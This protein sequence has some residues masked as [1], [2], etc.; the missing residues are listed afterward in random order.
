MAR[1]LRIQYPGAVYHITNRGNE[2][3]AIFGDDNDRQRFLEILARSVDTYQV[4]MHGFVLMSNHYHLLAETPLGNLAE[5]MR[6]FNITYT[7][8]FNRCHNRVGHLFQGRYK[9]VLIDKESYLAAVSKYIHLNPV[10]VSDLLSKPAAEKLRLLYAYQWSSL[11][12]FANTKMRNKWVEYGVVLREFGGDNPAGR[13]EYRRQIEADVIKGIPMKE[14]LIGQSILGDPP[15]VAWVEENFLQS[16]KDREQPS[17]GMVHSYLAKEK[18]LAQIAAATQKSVDEVVHGKG[19]IRQIVMDL[20]YRL[21]GMKNREIG[22]MLGIDYSTVSLNRKR[23]NEK[24][25][26]DKQLDLVI[27]AVENNLSKKKI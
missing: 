11:P 23:L 22:E 27:S 9:S 14:K 25:K 20:L 3:K 1:P 15:F 2:R 4:I 8:Y 21:G 5:F 26:K 16:G 13:K 10:K 12:G 6:Y 18:I 19:E 17:I 24:R 7:S